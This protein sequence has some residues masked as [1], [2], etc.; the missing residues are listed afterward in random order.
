MSRATRRTAG[1]ESK[2]RHSPL[3]C[4]Q[5]DMLCAG[6]PLGSVGTRP[7]LHRIGVADDVTGLRIGVQLPTRLLGDRAEVTEQARL[8]AILDRQVEFRA[9]SD[10]VEP[11]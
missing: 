6:S 5:G 3:R 9:G 4:A 1:S 11:V 8:R 7:E 2:N 10:R